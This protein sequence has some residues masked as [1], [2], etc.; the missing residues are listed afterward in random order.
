MNNVA[1]NNGVN[2]M[3]N[4]NMQNNFDD[5]SM[6]SYKVRTNFNGQCDETTEGETNNYAMKSLSS[7]SE[8]GAVMVFN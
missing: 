8:F 2:E 5:Q 6:P 1:V 7:S 3:P 4:Y